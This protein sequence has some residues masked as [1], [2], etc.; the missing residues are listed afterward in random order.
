MQYDFW[1]DG[2]VWQGAA[3][4]PVRVEKTVSIDS[5]SDALDVAYAL[6]NDSDA[7]LNVRFGIETN[8][9]FAGGNDSHTHI[10]YGGMEGSLAETASSDDISS[11]HL[12]SELWNI[13]VD[14]EVDRAATLW[15]F[16]LE[17]VSASEAGFES[18]YQGT[19]ILFLWP[20]SLQPGES[21]QTNL[22][23]QLGRHQQ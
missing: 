3:Q 22:Q 14:V 11:I 9:G 5:G 8:W 20:L 12:L 16:P 13:S 15:R 1:R 10:K 23:F 4:V 17:S 6:R 21:W 2:N 19:T 18:N 7:P